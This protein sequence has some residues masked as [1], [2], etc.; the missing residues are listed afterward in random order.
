[1]NIIQQTVFQHNQE[2]HRVTIAQLKQYLEL[3]RQ[4]K[5]WEALIAFAL[6][7]SSEKRRLLLWERAKTDF[8]LAD[9]DLDPLQQ[10][11]NELIAAIYTIRHGER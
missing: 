7:G 3:L 1:M 9:P 6:W 11:E 2:W 10:E 5:E 4:G 8:H